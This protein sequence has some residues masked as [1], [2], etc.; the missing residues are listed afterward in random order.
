MKL[1]VLA[2]GAH[3]DD[4]ELTC[5]G[6]VAK[7]TKS[8]HAVGILDLTRGELGTRGS[9]K[10]RAREAANAARI[11]GVEMRANLELKDGNIEVNKKNV[12]KL[13]T[14]L[15]K[16]KPAILLIPHASDRH[17]DHEHAHQLAKEA[18]Y[19][20]GLTNIRT[21]LRGKVQEHFRPDCYFEYMQWNTF[22]P[23]FIVDVTDVYETRVAAIR[24]FSSQFYDPRSKDKETL[25][26]RPQFLDFVETRAKYYGDLIGVD[27]GEPF[28][29]T[30][31]IGVR[32]LL[33]LLV[34]RG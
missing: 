6:T 15:R 18:W 4:I 28:F 7:L 8:G 33:N 25:L 22:T 26:S 12:S 14:V 13:I 21:R 3:P 1:D 24:A 30:K 31:P 10:L 9:P 16:Y 23:S 17:P 2:I 19:Y 27:Y 32:N 5:G 29:S 11:L 34:N 20:S